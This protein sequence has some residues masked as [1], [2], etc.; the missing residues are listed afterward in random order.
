MMM[1]MAPD[2]SFAVLS[3]AFKGNEQY[4]A[5]SEHASNGCTFL[6]E[7]RCELHGTGLQ[8]LECRYCHH[9]RV[10]Q[11]PKCHRDIERSWNTAAGRALVVRW[12]E[13]SE[14]WQK[15]KNRHLQAEPANST[16][17]PIT[18]IKLEK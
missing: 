13:A 2:R 7:G 17:R 10:G 9:T 18:S 8:P 15:Q 5:V 11:G 4:F 12:A 1:E 6:N 14:F 3:P 16:R